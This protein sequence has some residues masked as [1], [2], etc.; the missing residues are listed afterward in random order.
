MVHKSVFITGANG[1]LGFETSKIMALQGF[2]RI[3]MAARTLQ[4]AEAA[5]A[6]LGKDVAP[7]GIIETAGGF[8]MNDPESIEDA[9]ANLP[10]GKPYDIIFLQAG[11][12]VFGQNYRYNTFFGKQIERTIFQNAIGGY[13]T[14]VNLIKNGLVAQ[15][16]RIVFAGG[17]GARGIP[18]MIEKPVFKNENDFLD[19][20][21]GGN[22]QKKYNPMNG[23]GV[24]KLASAWII[25]K[26]AE[27][28]DG[29]TYVWFTPGLTHGT[30]GLATQS[31]VKRFFAEK[32]MF[33]ITAL[34][35]FSQSP[36]QGAEK[37]VD[38]LLGKHGVN[39]DVLGAPE[40]KVLGKIVDQKPMNPS[41]TNRLI[42]E[43]FWA[44]LQEIYPFSQDLSERE[45][46]QLSK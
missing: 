31:P 15:N 37:Y 45:Q 29:R 44:F 9:I 36:R 33:G 41:L 6:R 20:L 24:S 25:Q 26:L 16:A 42:I 35:G 30:N 38:A 13:I 12:V 39:G 46:L 5:R 10:K 7:K 11:G 34:L 43:S 32:I 28:N 21:T 27:L 17:E 40:G 2:G 4:K 8:D 23:I 19:Y 18:G 14:L 22:P 1:G 3:T